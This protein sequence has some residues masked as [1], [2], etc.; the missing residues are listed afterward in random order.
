MTPIQLKKKLQRFLNSFVIIV[1]C[2]ILLAF[3]VTLVIGLQVH[4]IR[5]PGFLGNKPEN[6][7]YVKTTT[8]PNEFTFVVV[9]D[10]KCGTATFEAMLDIIHEDKPAFVVVLGDFVDHQELISHKLFALEMTEHTKDF[11]MFLIPGNHDI[12]ANGPFGLEDFEK[13]YGPAQFYFT[14]GKNLFVFLNNI[15][16]YNQTDQYLK[17]LEQALSKQME[18]AEKIFV[19]MHIPPSGINSSLMCNGLPG[20]EEL[21]EIARTHHINYIFSGDHHGYVKTGKDG[22][23][24]IVTGGG[25]A[26]LRGKHGRF[27]HLV[28]MSIKDETIVE[29]VVTAKKQLETAEL[30]ERNIAIYIWPLIARNGLSVA[31]T[32]VIF[33]IAVWML[34]Y[35]LRRRKRL[36]K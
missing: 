14:L 13:I 33:G 36:L 28:R 25:G 21:L 20:S 4:T 18:G 2:L 9:G 31:I 6:I 12:D 1:L 29:T 24:F 32:V 5:F 22:T 27:H 26:K 17:F 15:S 16:P 11:P 23:A 19:F 3:I 30:I 34:I 8:D 7:N 35:S 10:V